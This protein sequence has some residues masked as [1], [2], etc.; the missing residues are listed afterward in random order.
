MTTICRHGGDTVY[1]FENGGRTVPHDIPKCAS[2]A[3]ARY[4][5]DISDPGWWG[6]VCAEHIPVASP[7]LTVER[8]VLT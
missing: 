1:F 8:V 7:N 5:Y 3:T 2:P 4:R 6:Y